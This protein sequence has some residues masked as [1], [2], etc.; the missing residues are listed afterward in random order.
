[1]AWSSEDQN[2]TTAPQPGLSSPNYAARLGTMASPV[3]S[4]SSGTT[5]APTP[6]T[7]QGSGSY[8]DRLNATAAPKPWE[9]R[10]TSRALTTSAAPR[11]VPANMS[12]Y[13]D[14]YSSRGRAR[15]PNEGVAI[16][17]EAA[18][19]GIEPSTL[20]AVVGYETIGTF[21]PGIA[22]GKK[23][24][25]RG[26]IQMGPSERRAYGWK[27]GMSFEEQLA[28]PVHN[29]LV[30][31][32]VRPGHGIAEVYSIINA[33]SLRRGQP[34]WGASDRP[35]WNVRR[36]VGEISRTQQPQ[37]AYLDPGASS[38]MI[39]VPETM[40]AAAGADTMAGGN[41]PVPRMRPRSGADGAAGAREMATAYAPSPEAMDA[42]FDAVI[43]EA[44][45]RRPQPPNPQ[46]R[47]R[48]DTFSQGNEYVVRRGDNLTKIGKRYGVSVQAIARA[49]GI[50]NPDV[51]P[52]GMRLTIPGGTQQ[53]NIPQ[54]R[55]RP[56][57]EVAIPQPRLRPERGVNVPAPRLRPDRQ[58]AAPP[59]RPAPQTAPRGTMTEDDIR[60]SVDDYRS[61]M[62]RNGAPEGPDLDRAVSDFERGIRR[63]AGVPALMDRADIGR[64][65]S[66][67]RSQMIANGAR[68]GPELDAMVRDYATRMIDMV[69]NGGPPRT[70]QSEP[71]A[72][73][74]V[75]DAT[76]YIQPTTLEERALPMVRP[77]MTD[78]QPMDPR[79]AD[80]IARTPA[81]ISDPRSSIARDP[82]GTIDQQSIGR[83]PGMM[84]R[85]RPWSWNKQGET[86]ERAGGVSMGDFPTRFSDP[87]MVPVDQSGYESPVRRVGFPAEARL[88][89]PAFTASN[90]VRFF[91]VG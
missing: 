48:R 91:A 69:R 2:P 86:V 14:P 45:D 84:T 33:G 25:Y 57:R 75:M 46:P 32:G 43:N 54:P 83:E 29:Y 22:G 64:S 35:G 49:N 21:D 40:M 79:V 10:E 7:A 6:G 56:S 60:R 34:R 26:L 76:G 42:P 38:E 73:S 74:G 17:R 85:T 55:L 20:A 18:R 59:A 65:V 88:G 52:V 28:G 30:D 50:R 27:D 72:S 87:G 19:L 81:V 90:G 9:T 36:H 63:D 77:N 53:A 70:S 51:I 58:Q 12:A 16:Q 8:A 89:P 13:T 4:P 11:K 1:M 62:I 66:N 5:M 3:Y 67:F 31:R 15:P 82:S 41:M 71:A 78:N 80:K 44:G 61:N 37:Y 23:N 39:D 68:P 47:P 24:R